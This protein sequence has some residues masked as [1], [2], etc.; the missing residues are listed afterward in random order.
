MTPRCPAPVDGRGAAVGPVPITVPRGILG[1]PLA[2]EPPVVVGRPPTTP[3]ARP[4]PV[5]G[6]AFAR[7]PGVPLARGVPPDTPACPIGN[8]FEPEPAPLAGA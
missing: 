3:F 6:P 2:A 5:A 8:G 1:P 4:A 7:A